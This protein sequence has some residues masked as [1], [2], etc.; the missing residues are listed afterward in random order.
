MGVRGAMVR[1]L[2]GDRALPVGN[3]PGP[4]ASEPVGVYG[5]V[6]HAVAG[7]GSGM[8]RARS[9]W[10]LLLAGLLV[11]VGLPVAGKW[12]RRQAAPRC[13]L[14]GLKIEPLYRVRVVDRAGS[15]HNFCCVHCAGLWLAR[16]GE[17]PEAVFVTDEAGGAELAARSAYFIRSAVVTNPVTG[18]RVHVFRER[19]AAEEHARAFGGRALTEAE[20]PF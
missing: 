19:M 17:R 16:Q 14:D 2:P 15:S 1:T 3:G 11:I 9:R 6:G 10:L 20:K 18:N 8:N 12:M 4:L 13:A 5:I 7:A